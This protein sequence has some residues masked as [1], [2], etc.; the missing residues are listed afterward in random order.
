MWKL[1]D[2]VKALLDYRNVDKQY[3]LISM[4]QSTVVAQ[5]ARLVYINIHIF[6]TTKGWSINIYVKRGDI[7]SFFKMEKSIIVNV[8][9]NSFFFPKFYF[10]NEWLSQV[11]LRLALLLMKCKKKKYA[12]ETDASMLYIQYINSI[13]QC[14]PISHAFYYASTG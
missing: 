4:E 11:Q 1:Q 13:S 2:R 6:F 7:Y 12:D 5:K 9:E 8:F 10:W 14:A 3:Y